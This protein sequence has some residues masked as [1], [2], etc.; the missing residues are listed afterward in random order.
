LEQAEET[1]EGVLRETRDSVHTVKQGEKRGY[2]AG[3]E[4]LDDPGNERLGLAYSGNKETSRLARS[5][6]TSTD[7]VLEFARAISI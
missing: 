1:L 6:I 4:E 7:H 3:L 5:L 2:L